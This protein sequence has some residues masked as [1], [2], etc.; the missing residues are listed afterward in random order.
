MD[1]FLA[2]LAKFFEQ[3]SAVFM[4]ILVA[5]GLAAPGEDKDPEIK[6]TQVAS[7]SAFDTIHTLEGGCT[8]GRYVYQVLIDS[9][10]SDETTPCKIVK[11]DSTNWQTVTVSEELKINHANDIAYDSSQNTLLISNNI[12]N[13]STITMVDPATLTVTG[14]RTLTEKIYSLVYVGERDCYFAFSRVRN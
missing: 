9:S 2:L 12:P 13:Y 7:I 10:I 5:L 8:D 4:S 3:L 6:Q 1:E 14:T 11:I